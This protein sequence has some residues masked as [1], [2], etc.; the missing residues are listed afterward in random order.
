MEAILFEPLEFQYYL[1][2]SNKRS[3]IGTD[4]NK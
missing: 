3:K 2:I 4:I 1:E